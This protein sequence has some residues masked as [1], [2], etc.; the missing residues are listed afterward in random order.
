MIDVT[1]P[2]WAQATADA[3]GAGGAAVP[4]IAGA[5][6]AKTANTA[7]SVTQTGG[8]AVPAA[9][10][11]D[12]GAPAKTARSALDGP[13]DAQGDASKDVKDTTKGADKDAVA[14][15]KPAPVKVTLP[16]KLPDGVSVDKDFVSGF[17]KQAESLG[18]N[19]DEANSLVGWYLEQEGQRVAK[20]IQAIE[21]FSKEQYETLAKD[22]EFGGKKFPESLSLVQKAIARFGRDTG[23]VDRLKALGLQNDPAIIKTLAAVGRA[24]SEDHSTIDTLGQGSDADRRMANLFPS[25][26]KLKKEVGA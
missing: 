13:G 1:K 3:A 9:T 6:P 12:G 10:K 16:E 2:R 21:Q 7:A 14:G 26:K 25:H 19:S 24:I 23:L 18:L 22:P 20:S 15:E 4:V 5:E 17:E 8:A 11:Q